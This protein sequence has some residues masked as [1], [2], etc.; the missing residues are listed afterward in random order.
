MSRRIRERFPETTIFVHCW[1]C[2]RLANSA[3][4]LRFREFLFGFG[5]THIG[6]HVAGTGRYVD[7][8]FLSRCA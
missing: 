3:G 4:E 7:E 2:D 6:E 8:R 1:A 5:D